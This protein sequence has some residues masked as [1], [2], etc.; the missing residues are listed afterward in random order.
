MVAESLPERFL[1]RAAAREH[2]VQPGISPPCG[3][4]RVGEQLD[5][6]LL[7]EAAGVEH[8]DRALG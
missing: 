8:V 6:L 4:E 1:L 2:E 3:E 5:A 7:G